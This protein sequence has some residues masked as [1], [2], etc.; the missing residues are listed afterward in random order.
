V[1]IGVTQV[2]AAAAERQSRLKTERLSGL[3][4]GLAPSGTTHSGLAPLSKTAQSLTLEIRQRAAPLAIHPTVGGD[5]VEDDSTGSL[6][7]GLRVR[8]QLERLRLL[9][10]L[11]LLVAAQA[12]DLAGVA[13]LGAGTAA[14][15][16]C[17][18][19]VVEQVTEDR[20]VGP[21]VER[22]A[23]GA[24]GTGELLAQ[25]RAAVA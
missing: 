4:P 3:P 22:L 17:V 11:E 18:R 19:E 5:G 9:I 12:V 20:P 23:A 1:A 2:A 10:A 8:E 14:A 15:Q 21:E 13:Q 6:Q 16:R 25:V 7:A 24:L